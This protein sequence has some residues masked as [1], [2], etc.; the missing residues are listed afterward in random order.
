MLQVLSGQTAKR[1]SRENAG[2]EIQR[3]Q[4]QHGDVR[5]RRGQSRAAPPPGTAQGE[6][7]DPDNR[8]DLKNCYLDQRKRVALRQSEEE[9]YDKAAGQYER[10]ERLL[11]ARAPRRTRR[12]AGRLSQA[13][14]PANYGR[15]VRFLSSR[16]NTA[17]N[18]NTAPVIRTTENPNVMTPPIGPAR[19]ASAR[20]SCFLAGLAERSELTLA[21][22]PPGVGG[23]T[24]RLI[25]LSPGALG[26]VFLLQAGPS[27]V[28]TTTSTEAKTYGRV[29]PGR[30]R[31]LRE[32][33]TTDVRDYRVSTRGVSILLRRLMNACNPF[34]IWDQDANTSC[35]TVR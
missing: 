4:H 6:K 23:L 26:F 2:C 1:I 30:P 7:Q 35:L 17:M 25:E 21:M 19:N 14:C 15:P 22:M 31:L 28:S 9:G 5:G 29:H 12:V 34:I 33:L 10:T 11:D 16:S 13:I 27:A 32:I 8:D 20:P 3:N 24:G 18:P